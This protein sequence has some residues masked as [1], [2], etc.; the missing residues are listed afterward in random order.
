MGY[1]AGTVRNS[2]TNIPVSSTSAAGNTANTGGLIGWH[3]SVDVLEECYAL[4]DVTGLGNYIGGLIGQSTRDIYNSFAAGNVTGGDS[5]GGLVGLTSSGV[6]SSYAL[7]N[8]SGNNRVG[9]L[10]GD[11]TGVGANNAAL[12]YTVTATNASAGRVFGMST[13]GALSNNH[14]RN[15]MTVT[16]NSVPETITSDPLANDGAN[17]SLPIS[18]TDWNTAGLN[19]GFNEGEPWRWDETLGRPFLRNVGPGANRAP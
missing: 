15:G 18:Q 14:A 7:G 12:N 5:V 11:S 10:V 13:A 17:L 4:G 3:S 16:I 9:G 8:V 1:N 2:Y 19:W 6:I